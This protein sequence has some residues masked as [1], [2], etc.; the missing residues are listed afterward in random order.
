MTRRSGPARRNSAGASSMM[1]VNVAS[2]ETRSK[3]G[4]PS[5]A[6]RSGET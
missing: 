4:L 5:A 1:A 2:S 6:G 3:G